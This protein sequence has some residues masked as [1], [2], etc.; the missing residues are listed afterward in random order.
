MHSL[1]VQ[2][3]VVQNIRSDVL[4]LQSTVGQSQAAVGQLQALQAG[5]QIQAL[6]AQQ[7]MQIQELLV[8]QQRA[9]ALEQSRILAEKVRGRARLRRFLDSDAY[10]GGGN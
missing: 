4:D 3:R 5:N 9:D 7:L 2:A 1:Q 8:A 10:P 6:T